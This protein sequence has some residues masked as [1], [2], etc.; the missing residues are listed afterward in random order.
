M[1]FICEYNHAPST[2]KHS[3]I[4]ICAHTHTELDYSVNSRVRQTLYKLLY[5]RTNVSGNHSNRL[6]STLQLL[7]CYSGLEF[8]KWNSITCEGY[9]NTLGICQYVG[10]TSETPR[11]KQE[12]PLLTELTHIYPGISVSTVDSL[13]RTPL[14]FTREKKCHA[15]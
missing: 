5:F 7:T 4:Q 8:N 11:L 6:L 10:S 9:W 12:Q 2:P 13:P 3:N 1:F 14:H 15:C